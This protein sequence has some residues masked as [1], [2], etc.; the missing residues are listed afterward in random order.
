M[1]LADQNATNGVIHVIDRVEFPI[2][3][4]AVVKTAERQSELG[5]LVKAVL[6]AGLQNTLSGKSPSSFRKLSRR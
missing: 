2:P 4:A 3:I 6:A 1:V 5:T